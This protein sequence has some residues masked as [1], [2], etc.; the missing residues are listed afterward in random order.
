MLASKFL[1][2]K[3][4]KKFFVQKFEKIFLSFATFYKETLDITLNKTKSVSIFII[5]IIIASILLFSFS[6]KELMPMEDRGAY[7]IIG[8]TDEGSSFEY[9]QEQAQKVEARLIP[10]L[11]AEDSPCPFR[12]GWDHQGSQSPGLCN[13]MVHHPSNV[14]QTTCSYQSTSTPLHCIGQ[15]HRARGKGNHRSL[16]LQAKCQHKIL[17]VSP[18]REELTLKQDGL[19]STSLQ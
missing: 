11:Q 3:T 2:K 7:L 8:A 17:V 13:S 9:T 19:H 4:S 1:N 10:L 16:F 12:T 15:F 14:L 6:K 18:S 5:F